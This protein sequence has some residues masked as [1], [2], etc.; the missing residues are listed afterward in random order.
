MLCRV[1]FST[2]RAKLQHERYSCPFIE[3]SPLDVLSSS[4]NKSVDSKTCRFCEKVFSE[5]RSRKRHEINQHKS[6]ASI[7]S[8]DSGRKLD[9]VKDLGVGILEGLPDSPIL[10]EPC[11]DMNA[12]W[13][14]PTSSIKGLANNRNARSF[15]VE[16]IH[17]EISSC[18]FC[19]QVYKT[20][21]RLS[22]HEETCT[23]KVPQ[24]LKDGCFKIPRI[25]IV[26]NCENLTDMLG[27][28]CV[29]DLYHYNSLASLCIPG[30]F[31]LV[32]L[33]QSHFGNKPPPILKKTAFNRSMD[34]LIKLLDL[35][36]EV[37][38]SNPF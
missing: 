18:K 26:P 32:F 33:G 23:F 34:I 14:T 21:Y 5:V 22:V 30:I 8:G 12:N 7:S 3:S 4:S 37:T 9:R 38:L 15:E 24:I 1:G 25:R 19:H 31:P 17:N 27:F 6:S 10:Q 2:Q 29:E 36:K 28:A 35:H 20:Q 11:L 16:V 13:K